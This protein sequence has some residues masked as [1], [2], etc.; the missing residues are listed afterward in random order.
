MA[1]KF[2]SLP[3]PKTEEKTEEKEEKEK[4]ELPSFLK[5]YAL[6]DQ[7]L[8]EVEHW[9]L[10]YQEADEKFK[11]K[12][13]SEG[14]GLILTGL[15]SID[16]EKEE[17]ALTLLEHYQEIT[18]KPISKNLREKLK[19]IAQEKWEVGKETIAL[20][21][22]IFSKNEKFLKE[23]I[24]ENM[25]ALPEN[26]KSAIILKIAQNISDQK[27]LKKIIRKGINNKESFIRS[28]TLELAKNIKDEE[29]LKKLTKKCLENNDLETGLKLAQN[30]KDE[31]YQKF[32]RGL[33]KE[34]MDNKDWSIKL[35]ALKL[36]KNI[37]DEEFLKKNY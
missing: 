15:E 17:N 6:P 23:L 3:L 9:Y 33:I 12:I 2:E 37:K 20:K 4:Q 32:L 29:F 1:N 35:A 21:T 28:N 7:N 13:K 26:N 8:A 24:E 25:L 34:G 36:A 18:G 27:L 16:L 5:M 31:K 19:E 22:L 11:E 10:K 30:L 14:E